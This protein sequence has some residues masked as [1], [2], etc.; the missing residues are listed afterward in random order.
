METSRELLLLLDYYKQ[1]SLD[2]CKSDSEFYLEPVHL[3][4]S[5]E[6]LRKH[7]LTYSNLAQLLKHVF[8]KRGLT[9]EEIDTIF[10][11]LA[12]LYIQHEHCGF[13]PRS[14]N[15]LTWPEYFVGHLF[16]GP[17]K[18]KT[19]IVPVACA[20]DYLKDDYV[21]YKKAVEVAEVQS[22]IRAVVRKHGGFGDA[23]MR[24]I[25]DVFDNDDRLAAWSKSVFLSQV[26]YCY[27]S[28]YAAKSSLWFYKLKFRIKSILDSKNLGSQDIRLFAAYVFVGSSFI[29]LLSSLIFQMILFCKRYKLCLF[30]SKSSYQK[31]NA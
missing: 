26:V 1:K 17:D 11:E 2:Y 27:A 29:Y 7:N 6:H 10:D 8:S 3:R 5:E 16:K 22:L 31:M 28:G 30:K 12:T 15:Y 24:E 9:F 23:T 19:F 4:G 25:W 21:S 14:F 20:L 13:V 18:Y